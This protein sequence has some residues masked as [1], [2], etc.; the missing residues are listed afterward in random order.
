MIKKLLKYYGKH[1][2]FLAFISLFFGLGL[3]IIISRPLGD[4]PLR[5]GLALIALAILGKLYAFFQK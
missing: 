1:P 2:I 4:H 5:Y 3:G